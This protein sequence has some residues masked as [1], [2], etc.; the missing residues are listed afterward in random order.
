MTT[1]TDMVT[2]TL[3]ADDLIGPPQGSWTYPDYAAVAD[4]GHRYELVDGVI[5]MAPV[6]T[7]GHQS[8]SNWF[9]FY[10]MTHIQI[11]GLGRVFAAPTDVE[12]GPGDVVQ[13]D[14]LV[15]LNGSSAAITA[16]RVIGAPDLIV[17]IASPSTSGYDRREKQD[18]YARAHVSEYWIVDPV[19]Q[20]IE[21]LLLR[22]AAYRSQGVF[23]RKATLPSRVVP[24]LPVQVE[25]FFQ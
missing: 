25:Q 7:T 20:S 4:D 8:A 6:P 19:G 13:P 1:T 14:V 21:V 15:V 18:T 9:L 2:V 5:Y 11:P 10:L 17:E 24:N 23:L 12:L 22:G 16:S 3:P